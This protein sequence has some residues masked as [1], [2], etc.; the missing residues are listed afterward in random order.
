MVRQW[1]LVPPFGGS[2]PSSPAI[3]EFIII[4][5][6]IEGLSTDVEESFFC[7]PISRFVKIL[8]AKMSFSSEEPALILLAPFNIRFVKFSWLI[9]SWSGS[10]NPSLNFLK[11]THSPVVDNKKA[12]NVSLHS[13]TIDY[14]YFT[15]S[16]HLLSAFLVILTEFRPYFMDIDNVFTDFYGFRSSTYEA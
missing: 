7:A 4:D 9:R 1:V 11:P 2:N 6:K 3:K 15:I 8:R 14:L 13:S 10:K 5:H 12:R 16:S